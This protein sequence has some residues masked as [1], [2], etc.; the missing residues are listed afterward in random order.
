MKI[1]VDLSAIINTR[2]YEYAVRFLFGGL[3]TAATGII[4]KKYGPDIGGLFLAFPA[5]F[6][7]AATLMEKHEKEKKEKL[8]M[9]GTKRAAQAVSTDAAG[10]S[11]GAIGLS[12]FGLLVWKTLA[13]YPAWLV[14]AGA[15]VAWY[16]SSFLLWELRKRM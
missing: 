12:V 13:A 10:A 8:G 6:P 15:T 7:A 1:Q 9:N 2:W 11:I 4:A 3:I 5:I 16:A 14:L